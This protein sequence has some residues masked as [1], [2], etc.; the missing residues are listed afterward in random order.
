MKA[1]KYLD[2]AK[3]RATALLASGYA[4]EG[5][6]QMLNAS[7]PFDFVTVKGRIVARW[8]RDYCFQVRV[9]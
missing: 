3:Q 2:L 4:G 5:I 7:F 1:M 9:V 8:G 6:L